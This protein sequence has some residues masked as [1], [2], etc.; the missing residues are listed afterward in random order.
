M[1]IT[2]TDTRLQ[3]TPAC[4]PICVFHYTNFLGS[5]NRFR[6]RPHMPGSLNILWIQHSFYFLVLWI[7]LNQKSAYK[8]RK[9][10]KHFSSGWT[11]I[12]S[13]NPQTAAADEAAPWPKRPGRTSIKMSIFTNKTLSAFGVFGCNLILK[14]SSLIK[15]LYTL[16]LFA[17]REIMHEIATSFN[18]KSSHWKLVQLCRCVHGYFATWSLFPGFHSI[19]FQIIWLVAG[20][21]IG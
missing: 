12:W 15:Q 19:F 6:L 21:I 2:F 17:M 18:K 5:K 9:L 8:N 3:P 7:Y 11:I 10:N 16:T 4:H 1:F 14:H 20:E 13:F